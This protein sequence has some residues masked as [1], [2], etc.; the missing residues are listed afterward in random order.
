[1]TILFELLQEEAP[2][3]IYK[4]SKEKF[5]KWYFPNHDFTI[6]LLWSRYLI[7]GEERMVNGTGSS[8][9]DLQI[10]KVDDDWAKELPELDYAIISDGHWFFRVMYLHEAS[11]LV[12][13]V[14]CNQPNI[15]DYGL[16]SIF[17]IAFRTAFKYIN[18][19][20][21]CKKTVT[22]MRTFAPAHFEN[23]FWD[24]GGYCNRTGPV[25]EGEVDFGSF[26]WK[27][28]NIQME[29]FERAKSEGRKNGKRFEVVD[30]TK[31]ML[32]RPDGHPGE[33]W[34][35]KWMR[36]YNDCTHWCLPGPVDLWSELLFAVLQRE[37]GMSSE[38]EAQT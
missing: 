33:H 20:K 9:F 22:L 31:A 8:T 5:Q 3:D 27:A 36:G 38:L 17:R 2:K 6:M 14:S 26:D 35:N 4:G 29:E 15:T 24:T 13:C 1:M 11:K 28:R 37:A 18:D 34:G 23:G 21:E 19:C 32:M 10:D 25:S 12:G 16:D 7:V 30:V